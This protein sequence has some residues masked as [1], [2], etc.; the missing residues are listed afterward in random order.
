MY[1]RRKEMDHAKPADVRLVVNDENSLYTKFSPEA[2]FDIGVKTYL[3]SKLACEGYVTSIK[4]TV[5]APAPI[6]E[7]RFLSAV[8]NWT[9][10][11]RKTILQEA[12]VNKRLLLGLLVVA[13]L[14]II[15][16]LSMSKHINVFS[17]TIIPVLGSV[18]LGRAAGI[19]ITDLPINDAKIKMLN[20]M[21]KN[22]VISFEYD[23][24]KSRVSG[25]EN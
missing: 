22:N 1:L 17:Y 11:E 21:E 23:N 14:F 4:L 20:A 9:R 16:S 19:F 13:S 7:E 12:T 10:D 18:A 3:K 8:A 15:I 5:T 25:Q 24:D 6:D 2:E